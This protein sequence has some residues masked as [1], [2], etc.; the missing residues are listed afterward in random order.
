MSVHQ[1]GQTT[2]SARRAPEVYSA[3]EVAQAAGVDGRVVRRLMAAGETA[4]LD[5]V[6]VAEREAVRIARRLRR[7][8][9]PTTRPV[10]G[11]ALLD[12]DLGDSPSGAVSVAMFDVGA[13]DVPPEVRELIEVLSSNVALRVLIGFVTMLIVSA[14]FSTLGGLL[15]AFF[16]RKAVPPP[17]S[18]GTEIVPPPPPYV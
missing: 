16:F 8:P 4:T 11:G 12:R 1:P 2:R 3:D 14:I 9:A 17:A 7:G 15:A 18:G 10:F 13:L 5:G 6:F